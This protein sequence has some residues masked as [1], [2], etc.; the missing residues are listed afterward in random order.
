MKTWSLS[1]RI[2][3]VVGGCRHSSNSAFGVMQEIIKGEQSLEE[4]EVERQVTSDE[5]LPRR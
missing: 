5:A 4:M 3:K 1:P 2:K